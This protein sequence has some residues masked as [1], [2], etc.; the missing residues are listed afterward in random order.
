M[1]D[2]WCGPQSVAEN[3]FRLM[4]MNESKTLIGSV[5]DPSRRDQDID[6]VIALAKI[7]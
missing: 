4:I 3:N 5:V 2:D 7:S 1:N 6:T